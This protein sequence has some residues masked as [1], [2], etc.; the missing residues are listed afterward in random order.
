MRP[1]RGYTSGFAATDTTVLSQVR[2]ETLQEKNAQLSATVADLT[3]QLTQVKRQLEWFKRQLFGPKSEKRLEF[4]PAEQ[5]SLFAALGLDPPPAEDTPTQKVT[6]RR[7]VKRRDG[8]VN[9][10][11]LRF[12][13]SVPVQTIAVTAPEIE[14]IAEAEREVIGEKV[15]HRLAQEPGSYKILRYVRQVVKRRD[16]GEMLTPPAPPNVLG[17]AAVD[18]SFLAGLLVDKF[19]YH[20]PL[21]RQHR[22]LADSGIRVSRRSLTNWAGRSIDLLG[23]IVSAQSAHILAGDVIAMDETTIKAGRTGPGK[24]RSAYYWPVYGQD[25]E[26]V[27]HYAPSRAHEHVETFLGDFRGTLLSDG[28]AAYEA[29]AKRRGLVHARCW[30]HSRRKFVEARSSD[31]EAVDRALS[32]IGVLYRHEKRIRKRKL[33]GAGKLAWRSQHSAPAVDA[34]FAWCRQQRQRIDLLPNDPFGKALAYAAER[35]AG[36]R[37]F[38]DNPEVAIDTNHLERGLRPIPMGRRNWLFAWTELGAER[39]GAIQSLLTTC[40]MHGVNPY[41]YLVDVL[42]RIDRHPA[43]RVIELTPRVWKELF[44]EKPLRSDLDRVRDPPAL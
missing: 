9:E 23:P 15:T 29:F 25:D 31:P 43:K 34:F 44:A 36:L 35:E 10:Q 11:G 5:A 8:S 40:R 27:F 14:A 26:L 17:R 33:D 30:S 24:M 32:L 37:V 2:I 7:R 39:V 3:E 41:T 16:T 18:V 13:D 42:Q 6:Y 12:D 19:R 4:D 1:E 20:L 38:L 28:Y 21:H 22:R